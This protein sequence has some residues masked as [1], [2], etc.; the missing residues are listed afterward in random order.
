[1]LIATLLAP[2]ALAP[3]R[4]DAVKVDA[5]F[6]EWEG[7]AALVL[8][9][10]VRGRVD[11]PLDLGPRVQIA[12]SGTDL[13]VAAQVVDDRFQFGDGKA[14]DGLAFVWGD[15]PHRLD[16]VLRDLED[17]PPIA[18]VDGQDVKGAT[19]RGTYR[20]DGWAVEAAIP[21]SALPGLV[22]GPVRFAALVQDADERGEEPAIRASAPLDA[23]GAPTAVTLDLSA[24]AGLE[25]RYEAEQ[26]HA[27]PLKRLTGNL[28]GGAGL[29][30]V[31]RI[32]DREIVV[33]GHEL[34]D[35]V[36]YTFV[37]HGWRAGVTL[38]SAE[39]KELDGR[40]GDE[41][42][43]VHR[44]WAVPGETEVEVAEIWSVFD[45]SLRC[46]FAQKTLER[47]PSMGAEAATALAFVGKK[48][49][50]RIEVPPAKVTGFNPGNYRSVDPPDMPFNP[51]PMPWESKKGAAYTFKG[52]AWR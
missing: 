16:I 3:I 28:Y 1:M 27:E 41:L 25:A 38:V 5:F 2:L 44:E 22:G 20:K 37:T 26:D 19:L 50:L 7:K 13:L 31:V 21:L 11:G 30:E 48:P 4:A 40:P 36:G 14:G 10:A 23:R 42:Y 29:P 34:P 24:S 51:L 43:V 35:G 12:W 52:D 33:L 49:P 18:R 17:V 6:N 32:S 15:P 46:L 39:L 8:S 9:E 45:G 47:T